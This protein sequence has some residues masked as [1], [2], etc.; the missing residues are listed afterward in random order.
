MHQLVI[1][2][3]E[4]GMG[5]IDFKSQPFFFVEYQAEPVV[6]LGYGQGLTE[7]ALI[8]ATVVMAVEMLKGEIIAQGR[9]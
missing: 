2:K 1:C 3:N 4:F 6:V 9:L 7:E 5:E 8:P